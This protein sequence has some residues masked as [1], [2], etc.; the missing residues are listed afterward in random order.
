MDESKASSRVGL[1]HCCHGQEKWVRAA[2][3]GD[4]GAKA[5][6]HLMPKS[7][8]EELL[9][10]PGTASALAYAR[11]REEEEDQR[12]TRPHLAV[13]AKRLEP[14]EKKEFEPTQSS[15]TARSRSDGDASS[16]YLK[17]SRANRYA[18]SSV[19]S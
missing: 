3:Q 19:R 9:K 8:L 10:R 15:S 2:D 13:A 6:Q 5:E 14:G 7:R 11:V 16:T 17:T 12:R 18:L 4:F 1:V